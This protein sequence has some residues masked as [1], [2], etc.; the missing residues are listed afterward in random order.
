[1]SVREALEAARGYIND[2]NLDPHED[3]EAIAISAQID[4]AL[5]ELDKAKPVAAWTGEYDHD[6]KPI[7]RPITPPDVL[8]VLNRAHQKMRTY[9]SVFP[10][11][12]EL[13][14]LLDEWEALIAK[15]EG[16]ANG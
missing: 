6:G 4:A 16:G 15:L 13:R 12:K 9:V 11:D 10:G 1:M 2:G 8:P 14:S 5:R 3:E 7:E